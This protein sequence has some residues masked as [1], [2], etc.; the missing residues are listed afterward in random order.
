MNGV[1][2]AYAMTGWRIGYA[3]GPEQADQGDGHG[4]G[5]ADLRRLH[6]RAMG[7]GRS[8]ERAAGF[9]PKNKAC[10]RSAAISSCRCSTRR[11][12]RNARRRKARSMSIRPAPADRQEDA[13]GQGHRRPCASDGVAHAP[14]AITSDAAP[15]IIDFCMEAFPRSLTRLPQVNGGIR[16]AIRQSCGEPRTTLRAWWPFAQKPPLLPEGGL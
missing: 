8:A 5:P 7:G 1:S 9:H 4:A 11:R 13:G 3:A 2:K 10:S 12:H 16:L 15:M 14:R 6:H